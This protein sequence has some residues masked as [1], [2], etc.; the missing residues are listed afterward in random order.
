MPLTS[1]LVAWGYGNPDSPDYALRHIT[2]FTECGIT[3]TCH[4]DL[5]PVFSALLRR[6][7]KHGVRF[8]KVHDDWGYVNKGIEG[9]GPE[10][11]SWHS[12]GAAIDL[13]ATQNPMGYYG[14]TFPVFWTHR[15]TH[16][17]G[18]TWGYDWRSTRPDPM[19]FEVGHPLPQM[20]EIARRVEHH[21]R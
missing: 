17:L 2:S 3:L 14:T 6:L 18:L 15:I 12:V 19:H 21:R 1:D 4:R 8:D 7:H 11:K 9:Y 20:R 5:V 13:N 10:H 16:R